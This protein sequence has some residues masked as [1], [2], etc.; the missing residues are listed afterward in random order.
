MFSKNQIEK[1]V[2]DVVD[3]K[4]KYFS[5]NADDDRFDFESIVYFNE[6]LFCDPHSII[7]DENEK[8][9]QDLLDEKQD[10]PI[11]DGENTFGN[12]LINHKLY[13]ES[14]SNLTNE[15]IATL[16]ENMIYW[17]KKGYVSSG[18]AKKFLQN[19]NV[20]ETTIYFSYSQPF[21]VENNG[22][23]LDGTEQLQVSLN[24][25]SREYTYNELS[26]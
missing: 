26:F 19:V 12:D 18:T 2:N 5:Y 7:V 23:E 21:Y 10:L 25:T 1:I 6:G 24:I 17:I 15:E 20:D 8:S 22:L 11:F 4:Y 16:Q 13:N 9:L 3:N 14:K